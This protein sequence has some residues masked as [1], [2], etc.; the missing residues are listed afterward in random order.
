MSTEKNTKQLY[1]IGPIH[2]TMM[3]GMDGPL[4]SCDIWPNDDLRNCKIDGR[5]V[6]PDE[7]RMAR[8]PRG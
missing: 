3:F 6:S 4:L 5:K 7:Y 8:G 2:E 1:V